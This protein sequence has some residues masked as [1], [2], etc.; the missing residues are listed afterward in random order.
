MLAPKKALT[1]PSTAKRASW[2]PG[3][4]P[5]GRLFDHRESGSCVGEICPSDEK[6]PTGSASPQMAPP[7]RPWI[8][9]PPSRLRRQFSDVPA[10]HR[11]ERP[12]GLNRLARPATGAGS[13]SRLTIGNMPRGHAARTAVV[14]GIGP[15][16]HVAPYRGEVGVGTG[17]GTSVGWLAA[18]TGTSS[19]P[20]PILFSPMR[21]PAAISFQNRA[22]LL[23]R[24]A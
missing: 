11:R 8:A 22:L 14:Q 18:I 15:V 4:E 9:C 13:L 16:L 24:N 5:G 17:V 3:L 19:R 23:M 1:K 20:P 6:R 7:C 10:N 12:D 2:R 21:Y